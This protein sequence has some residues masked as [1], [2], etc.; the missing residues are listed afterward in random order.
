MDNKVI[1]LLDN[2]PQPSHL[3]TY[4]ARWANGKEGS[5]TD[6]N[7]Q[8]I[9]RFFPM[10]RDDNGNRID[11]PIDFKDYETNPIVAIGIIGYWLH[12]RKNKN[13]LASYTT[14]TKDDKHKNMHQIFADYTEDKLKQYAERENDAPDSWRRDLEQ[15]FYTKFIIHNEKPLNKQSEALFEY[16]TPDD[17]QMV[18][19][20]M[21]EYMHYLQDKKKKYLPDTPKPRTKRQP[22]PARKVDIDKIGEHFKL[23]FDKNTHLPILKT[24]LETSQSDKDLAKVALLIYDSKYFLSNDYRTF[25]K[26]YRDYCK[27]VGCEF[28]SS[29]EPSKLR[30]IDRELEK[31]YYFLM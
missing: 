29:Y 30:P 14:W 16:I 31:R 6:S 12:Y 1:S 28:H 18:K 19:D 13:R 20:V 27:H 3:Y 15:E 10:K 9:Y 17:R 11:E 24:L 21:K 2:I 7:G 4:L 23:G 8:G 26:W 22:A 25:S 5:I